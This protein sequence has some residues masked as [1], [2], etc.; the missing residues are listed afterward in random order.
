[1]A[2]RDNMTNDLGTSAETAAKAASA[3]RDAAKIGTK[4]A[5]G[6][7]AGA[8]IDAAKSKTVR[9]I[10]IAVICIA[11]ILPLLLLYAIPSTTFSAVQSYIEKM[12]A[13]MME[14]ISG[15]GNSF[16]EF[17]RSIGFWAEKIGGRVGS[18]NN[19]VLSDTVSSVYSGESGEGVQKY[20]SYVYD[21]VQDEEAAIHT[22]KV[23][24]EKICSLFDAR[25]SQYRKLLADMADYFTENPPFEAEAYDEFRVST[26]FNA[27]TV[28][29]RDAIQ[30][31]SA[32]SVQRDN[33]LT[34]VTLRS[35]LSWIGYYNGIWKTD[36][37]TVNGVRFYT[38]NWHG[39]FMPQYKYEQLS[40]MSLRD[41]VDIETDS[42]DT[43]I[44]DVDPDSAAGE[45]GSDSATIRTDSFM[46]QVYYVDKTNGVTTEYSTYEYTV[47]VKDPETGDELYD[48][49]G[50]P[51]LEIKQGL[52]MTIRMDVILVGQDEI[53]DSVMG[54][55]SGSLSNVDES[56][57][58]N[59]GIVNAQ[60]PDLLALTWTSDGETYARRTGY[61]TQ[62][63]Y[64]L[65]QTIAEYVG[66]SISVN[67]IDYSVI[68][69]TQAS[70]AAAERVVQI[71]EGELGTIGGYPYWNLGSPGQ[72]WCNWFIKWCGIQ[73]GLGDKGEIFFPMSGGCIT[74]WRRYG[75][76]A[77]STTATYT[78]G[79]TAEGTCIVVDDTVLLVSD[80]LSSIETHYIPQRGDLVLFGDR[81][82]GWIGHIGIVESYDIY[83]NDLVTI[84]GNTGPGATNYDRGV[85]NMHRTTT[86]KFGTNYKKY[87]IVGFIHLNYPQDADY[88]GR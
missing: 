62:Y 65:Q 50:D 64:D 6:N 86:Q 12:D 38:F 20:G 54:F 19:S 41:E 30:Y 23:Q 28:S 79:S 58:T 16:L 51:V 29:E 77:N 88:L 52:L 69:G 2:D 45:T 83:T 44:W 43:S 42:G 48:E 71:A 22:I 81:E 61:Q 57:N 36:A 84:E 74:T 82:R 1:M 35:I 17:V 49:N 73:A 76:T 11:L 70:T 18:L 67:G 60:D 13:E 47:P 14:E 10:V 87:N 7:V 8:A 55:W 53:A 3:V 5:S 78:G 72:A 66:I 46:E 34:N 25:K 68:G 24:I 39:D 31:L 15:S 85:Y 21:T 63:F 26:E 32:Y 33:G 75:G 27:P 37:Y 80:R 4:L 40:Q 9:N 59:R 56:T